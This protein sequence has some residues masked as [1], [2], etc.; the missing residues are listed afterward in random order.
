MRKRMHKRGGT[1]GNADMIQENKEKFME[2]SKFFGDMII[3]DEL[4]KEARKKFS[5]DEIL[6]D[7]FIEHQGEILEKISKNVYEN[8]N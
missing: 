7:Y 6:L 5:E 8:R 4:I 2:F 1:M 3:D